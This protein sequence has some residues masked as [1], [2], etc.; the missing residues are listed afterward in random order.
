MSAYPNLMLI[1]KERRS[2]PRD[3]ETINGWHHVANPQV[4][5]F[6]RTYANDRLGLVVIESVSHMGTGE[7]WRHVSVSHPSRVPDWYEIKRVRET[8]FRPQEYVIIVF[9]PEGDYVNLCKNC[10]HLWA[11]GGGH[12]K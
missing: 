6:S 12:G 4:D 8:F 1:V 9:P 7:Q 2:A 10:I 5:S 11:Q 3:P